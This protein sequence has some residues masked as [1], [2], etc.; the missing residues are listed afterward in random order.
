MLSS[1]TR[2]NTT[3]SARTYQWFVKRNG[4]EIVDAVAEKWANF[5][6]YSEAMPNLL[7]N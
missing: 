2:K 6:V 3:A 1:R 5:L 4:N 7:C